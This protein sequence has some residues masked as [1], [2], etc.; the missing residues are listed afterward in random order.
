MTTLNSIASVSFQ[1]TDQYQKSFGSVT[2]NQGTLEKAGT[3]VVG[4]GGT[5]ISFTT[6]TDY[7]IFV[8]QIIVPLTNTILSSTGEFVS[9][10]AAMI[11]GVA[12]ANPIV[13]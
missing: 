10:A 1:S 8:N 5:Q 6:V 11:P 4:Y 2:Y 3:L 9:P 13:D 7:L 12:G